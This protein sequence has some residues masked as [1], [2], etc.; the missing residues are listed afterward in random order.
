MTIEGIF[1]RIEMKKTVITMCTLLGLSGGCATH[2][3]HWGYSGDEGAKNWA[4]LSA[5]YEPCSGK[6]QSPINL[7]G[8]IEAD[9][10]PISFNYEAGGYE[11]LNNGHTVQLN[12]QKGSHITLDGINFELLQFHF[13]APS[14]NHINGHSYL[15]EA[16]LVHADKN[17]NLAVVAV[18]FKEG[19]SNSGLAQAW[20]QMPQHIGI[21]HDLINVV[22]VDHI[23]PEN[24]DYY[25]FNG[26]LTTPPC[27]EG[28]R[29]LVMKNV[30]TASKQQIAAFSQ[31]LHEPNN[32]PLQ[33]INSRTIL[34]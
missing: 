22:S 8:F 12:Y 33:S 25:R 4:T 13:H 3:T 30:M 28:V 29:W 2:N 17:G 14:E 1:W 24:R 21:K 32:R 15:L 20:N 31:V 18:M 16:H 19:E 11:I 27:S 6:N 23:L 34:Q 9:L 5:E 26:S 10:S 7:S